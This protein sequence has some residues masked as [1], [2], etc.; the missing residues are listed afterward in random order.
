MTPE[1]IAITITASVLAFAAGLLVRPSPSSAPP[2]RRHADPTRGAGREHLPTRPEAPIPGA[3]GL[4]VPGPIPA[5][6]G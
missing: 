4:R 6:L 5:R 3:A 2:R 1:H